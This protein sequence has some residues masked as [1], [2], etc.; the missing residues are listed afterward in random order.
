MLFAY[1]IIITIVITIIT[2]IAKVCDMLKHLKI[3]N[4]KINYI[5]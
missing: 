3:I 5:L 2:L 1:N 4:K